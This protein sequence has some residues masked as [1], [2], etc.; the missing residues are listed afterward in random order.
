VRGEPADQ[1]S[2]IFSFGGILYE[3]LSGTRAFKKGTSAE[4]MTAILNE[5]P[6][7]FSPKVGIAPALDRIVRHCMEKQPAQ[8]FQSAQDIAF[9]LESVSSTSTASAIAD[10]SRIRRTRWVRTAIAALA[11][12]GAGLAMGVWVRP[13]APDLHPRL[14]RI[15]FSRLTVLSARF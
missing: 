9:D 3:M 11:I 5:E 13:A 12:L 8:R 14:H 2:D 1:R 6:S 15:T 7:E 4:T 10:V